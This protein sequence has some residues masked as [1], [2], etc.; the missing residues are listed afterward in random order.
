M[1]IKDEKYKWDFYLK[2]PRCKSMFRSYTLD[3][4]LKKFDKRSL[5][6]FSEDHYLRQMGTR[7]GF[8]YVDGGLI[9]DMINMKEQAD[10]CFGVITDT[11]TA[12][13]R[14][15]YDGTG[16]ADIPDFDEHARQLIESYKE[17]WIAVV[18]LHD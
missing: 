17:Y 7:D 18:D 15:V 2:E 12:I 13:A 5:F 9:S 11:G 16:W 10:H 3:E 4:M 6:L 1:D 8:L 14:E